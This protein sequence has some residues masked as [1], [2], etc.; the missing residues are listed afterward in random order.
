MSIAGTARI[1]QTVVRGQGL[2]PVSINQDKCTGCALCVSRCSTDAITLDAN[3]RAI[4]NAD[5]CLG[6]GGCMKVCPA[7]AIGWAAR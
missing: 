7:H 1:K 2:V 5:L 4:V 6:I 3:N